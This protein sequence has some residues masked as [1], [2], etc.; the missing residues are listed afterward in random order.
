[1]TQYQVARMDLSTRV[2][3]GLKMLQNSTE[4]GWGWVT[5]KAATYG[6]SRQMLYDIRDQLRAALVEALQPQAPGPKPH[7]QQVTIDA[8]YI[9]WATT[10][11]AML[12]GSTRDIQQGLALLFGV[13][14]SVGFVSETLQA[15]GHSAAAYNARVCPGQP[16]LGEADEVFQ[17]MMPCLTVVDGQS[18]MVL[19][20]SA[21]ADRSGDS[22]ARTFQRLTQQGVVFQDIVS[23]QACGLRA[24][25]Q[26]VGLDAVWRLDLFHL[27]QA[28]QQ[29]EQKLENAAYRAIDKAERAQAY[30]D[31]QS[32]SKR[33]IGRPRQAVG[34][35]TAAQAQQAQSIEQYELWRWLLAEVRFALEPLHGYRLNESAAARAT[36]LVAAELMEHLDHPD[37]TTF[38]TSLLKNLD[39]LLAPLCWLEQQLAAAR[40]A[41]GPEDEALIVWVC[42]CVDLSVADLP[43]TLQETATRYQQALSLFHRASSHAEAFHS[44]LRPYLVI[45][46]TLPKW[47]LPLAMLFWNHHEFQRG[48]RAGHSPV[49]LASVADTP[50]LSAVL[51]QICQ[52]AFGKATAPVWAGC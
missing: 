7:R 47:L 28:G 24:G 25:L 40:Q 50:A 17:G 12:K 2:E 23:D 4:R 21:A 13:E 5:E 6:V 16:V 9:R 19:N 11:L 35:V 3:I 38:A 15:V 33:R 49:E 51:R 1:M 39:A 26:A 45:H 41:L 42:R 18:F 31:E 8:A 29:I 34:S 43:E 20:L 27:V 30:V 37:C 32:A 52:A 10:V 46:R 22:W 44:W 14:R 48:K 36:L